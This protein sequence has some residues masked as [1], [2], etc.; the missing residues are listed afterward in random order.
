MPSPNGDGTKQATTSAS[1]S[2]SSRRGSVGQS[3]HRETR[4]HDLGN[5]I[6]PGR[7]TDIFRRA[8]SLT[9]QT[10]RLSTPSDRRAD[11]LDLDGVPPVV[12]EIVEVGELRRRRAH[13]I[14]QGEPL[15]TDNRP[16]RRLRTQPVFDAARRLGCQ[17]AGNPTTTYRLLQ[18][19]DWNLRPRCWRTG[20]TGRWRW[21]RSRCRRCGRRRRLQRQLLAAFEVS[22]RFVG[23]VRSGE[24]DG[25]VRRQRHRY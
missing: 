16:A 19:T 23:T 21:A 6:D 4:P 11:V 17:P 3:Y 15:L 20:W 10:D 7:A 1:S 2:T 18:T 5:V 13:E 8:G 12:A 24:A 14:L 25:A 9:V 22:G